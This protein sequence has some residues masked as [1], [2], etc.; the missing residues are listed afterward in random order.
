[1]DFGV[2]GGSESLS[3]MRGEGDA[4]GDCDQGVEWREIVSGSVR[5]G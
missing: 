2:C 3:T 1:M 5:V 4:T